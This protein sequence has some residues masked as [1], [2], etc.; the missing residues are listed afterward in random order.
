MKKIIAA[1][2]IAV[3]S[4]SLVACGNNNGTQGGTEVEVAESAAELLTGVFDTFAEKL[5]PAYEMDAADVKLGFMGGYFNEEDETTLV[6][7][8]PG[9]V[10]VEDPSILTV[11]L[12][13]EDSVALVDDAA[14]V[15][16][17]MMTNNFAAVAYHVADTTNVDTV[18]ETLKTA[19]EGNQWMC[20]QPDGF[21]VVKV[22]SYVVSFYG[23]TDNINALKDALTETYETAEVAYE[24]SF[25][26]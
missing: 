24:G 26:E 13:P 22:G 4:L 7:G 8:G 10:P 23:L 20:G 16:H 25:I 17:A 12:L 2:L 9:A 14:L 11:G 19:M 6:M 5:A 21:Y 1:M 3:M 15:M 18:A